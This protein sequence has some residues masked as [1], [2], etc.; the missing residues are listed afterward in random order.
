MRIVD[1][2]HTVMTTVPYARARAG[3]GTEHTGLTVDRIKVD[4]V[5]GGCDAVLATGDL[6]G[7]AAS[8]WGGDPVLLGI[9]VADH[10]TAWSEQGLLPPPERIGIVLAGDLYSAPKADRRGASGDVADV[11]LAFAALG[12]PFLVGVAGN[13]D[14]VDDATVTA[15]RSDAVLLD[16]TG[17]ERAG[18]LFAG[19]GGII[20]DPRHPG[21]SS[22]ADFLGRLDRLVAGGPALL[23][24]HEGP[25]GEHPGQLGNPLIRKR[26]ERRPPP[27]TV[28]GHVHWDRPV[29][30]L[31]TGHIL[32]VDD[33][34]AVLAP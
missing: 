25:S 33:R 15:I 23:A 5:P 6:Q 18:T 22:E 10:I 14:V 9:A 3:G 24:L 8:P 1:E 27:L 20:G 34:I 13:H 16:G 7:V 26:L 2:Q 31:G 17:A 32:N 29:S 12:G 19:I 28:C 11:W 30:R 4:S 21:R